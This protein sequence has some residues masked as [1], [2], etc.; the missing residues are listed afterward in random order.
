MA[1]NIQLG[2]GVVVQTPEQGPPSILADSSVGTVQIAPEA[3]TDD[4]I[5]PVTITADKIVDNTITAT[6]IASETITAG[7][8]ANQTITATQIANQTITLALLDPATIVAL[9]N[10]PGTVIDFA[11]PNSPSGYLLCDGTPVSRTTYAALFSSIGTY[12]G[13]GDGST[14]FNLPDLR[15]LFTRGADP[16]GVHDPDYASRTPLGT[17]TPGQAGS[18]QVD[19]FLSHAHGITINTGG[20]DGGYVRD[21]ASEPSGTA[22]TNNAGGNE[23][24]PKNVYV[25]KCIKF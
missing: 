20:P 4:K 18:Y 16:T 12:W 22:L 7:Q 14:T 13:I 2:T 5:A 15:G 9:Q 1:Q 19:Q 11:G 23:T 17:G 10:A 3:V 25:T 8:I 6:Q 24:R 21:N